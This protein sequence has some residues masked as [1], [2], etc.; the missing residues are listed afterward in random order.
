MGVGIKDEEFVAHLERLGEAAATAQVLDEGLE[1]GLRDGVF[2]GEP[3]LLQVGGLREARV[4]A[5]E[6]PV[7]GGLAL[8]ARRRRRCR[9]WWR[10]GDGLLGGHGEAAATS[11]EAATEVEEESPPVQQHGGRRRRSRGGGGEGFG[12]RKERVAR[13]E[14]LVM[15]KEWA[16]DSQK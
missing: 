4:G 7:V 1:L 15:C 13:N 10:G 9:R 11:E 6:P 14:R 2:L 16:E 5:R 3:P 8:K 12:G